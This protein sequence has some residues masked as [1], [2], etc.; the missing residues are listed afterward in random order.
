MS[1]AVYDLVVVGA[2]P[3]GACAAIAAADAGAR[4]LLVE[5]ARFPRAKVCGSCLTA[6]GVRALGE[7]GAADALE[8]ARALATARIACGARELAI[9]RDAGVAVARADLDARL[10][11]VARARGVEVVEGVRARI[12]ARRE[13]D[14]VDGRTACGDAAGGAT[15]ARRARTAAGARAPGEGVLAPREL[16][17][18]QADAPARTVA[19]RTVIVADGLAGSALDEVEASEGF[20]WLVARRSRIGFGAIVAPHAVACADGEV[21]LFVGRGGYIGAV[22]LASGEVDLAAAVRPEVV[23]A[24]GGVAACAA[25]LLG[26]AL[27][28]RAAIDAAPWKGTPELTR[29]RARVAGDGILVVGDAAGYV[30]PFTGEGMTWAIRSGAAAG[31][32]AARDARA[33]RAWP[34]L[35]ARLVGRARAR[36]RAI[37]LLLRAPA[38]VG[39][40]LA[41]GARAPQP[42]ERLALA[43]GS[44]GVR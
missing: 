3:A 43:I 27:R 41:L 20:G 40:L 9:A 21:R 34:A 23:R 37:A 28:D 7:L 35:H 4:T 24:A 26:G 31:A 38:L 8:D 25:A 30:E 12:L 19:V 36:C 17:L 39:P 11:A 15:P 33:H 14:A 5:R 44:G 32:L 16:V 6:A 42:F 18:S 1:G 13:V 29:R 2:G 10:V 22:R